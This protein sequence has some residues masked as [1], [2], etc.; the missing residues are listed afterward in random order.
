MARVC[1]VSPATVAHWIDQGHLRGHR[2]PTGRRRVDSADL[3]SFLRTHQMAVPEDLEQRDE[4]DVVVVVE[5]DPTYLRALVM[6]IER[7]DLDV[8]VV[9]ATN[10]VDGLLEI[11]RVQPSLVLLDYGLPDLNA[12]QVLQRLLEPGR[13]LNAEV[14]VMTAWL[15]EEAGAELRKVGVKTIV[16]KAEGMSAVV[17]AMRQAL[18]RQVAA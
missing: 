10:G 8:E 12:V 1:Q 14:I 4:R 5:D 15:P 18:R 7:S 6:T 16:N 9:Q 2:T 11:G 3:I 13:R 17:D